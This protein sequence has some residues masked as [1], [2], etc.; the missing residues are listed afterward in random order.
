MDDDRHDQDEERSQERDRLAL[1]AMRAYR[2]VMSPGL[3]EE[4][5]RHLWATREHER[6]AWRAVVDAVRA[7]QSEG[8]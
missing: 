2:R 4:S 6:R 8:A 7:A 1:A 3:L 5:I